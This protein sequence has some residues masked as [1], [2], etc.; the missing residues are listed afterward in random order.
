MEHS[1]LKTLLASE[2]I[3][4]EH[5]TCQDSCYGTATVVATG[6][7]TQAYAYEWSITDPVQTLATA[8]NLCAGFYVVTI[9]DDECHRVD[10]VTINEDSIL[11]VKDLYASEISCFGNTA[12]SVVLVLSGGFKPYNV[13][14]TNGELIIPSGDVNE[15]TIVVYNTLLA[16]YWAITI[17]DAFECKIDTSI[18]IA[19]PDSLY[20]YF[21]APIDSV[22]CFGDVLDS[23]TVHTIGGTPPYSFFWDDTFGK[24]W[25]AEDSIAYDLPVGY[26]SVFV[27]DTNNCATTPFST[28][29]EIREPTRLVITNIETDSTSCTVAEGRAKVFAEGGTQYEDPTFDYTYIWQDDVYSWGNDSTNQEIFGLEVGFYFITVTDTLG[30]KDSSI[31]EIADTSRLNIS[32]DSVA[33][34]LCLDECSGLAIVAIDDST[35]L[36]YDYNFSWS[37]GDTIETADSLCAEWYYVMVSDTVGCARVDSV[38]ITE[39]SV[40]RITEVE[41]TPPL[42]G[43]YQDG[44]ITV[45]AAGGLH[46]DTIKYDF[47]WQDEEGEPLDSVEI[48]ADST[49]STASYLAA[50]TYYV[51]VVNE[52][53]F[54]CEVDSIIVLEAPDTVSAIIDTMNILC[55]GEQNGILTATGLGG[56]GEYTYLWDSDL[57]DPADTAVIDSLAEGWYFLTVTDTNECPFE[58]SAHI[59]EPDV[60]S[61][62]SIVAGTTSCTEAE[63]GSR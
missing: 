53:D 9:T 42:C 51:T 56:T 19:E 29:L 46:N 7:P 34:L 2:I 28:D 11:V 62:G 6:G 27:T 58:D 14:I 48:F 17:L 20:A 52:H 61:I 30:C 23:V 24:E 59:V 12:D 39:D 26:Y 60:L 49:Q 45:T 55:T 57:I 63:V 41:L 3:N 1:V 5:I 47:I 32:I 25:S 15:D 54:I 10:S 21:D 13:T 36:D 38:T 33:H 8:T 22:N 35:V 4:I 18:T 50:G 40:L 16:G 31:V 44:S 37:N 43:G